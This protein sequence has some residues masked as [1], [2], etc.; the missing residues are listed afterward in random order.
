M[1][2][3]V[4]AL[5]HAE[6]G[7]DGY[8]GMGTAQVGSNNNVFADS[9]GNVAGTSPHMGG[10]FGTFGAAVKLNSS[11]GFG[12][13]M[14]LRFAQGD[15]ASFNYRPIFYDFNGMWTPQVSK[16]VVPEFQAGFGGLSLRFYDPSTRYIDP[17]TGR[18]TNFV[19]STN[20]FQ[21][22]AS[23]GL[24]FRVKPRVFVRPTFDYRWVTNLTDQFKSNNVL[25]VS[26]AVG[27]SSNAK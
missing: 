20:H 19:G 8:F 4:A 12:G 21:L 18:Y 22:H 25:G 16:S 13:Q 11:F 2:L 6:A 3:F 17:N 23:A 9:S 1:F 26:L 7:L 10:T 15:Y 14:S 27:F 24:R 5:A